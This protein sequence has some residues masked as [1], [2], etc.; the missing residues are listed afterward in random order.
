MGL[1]LVFAC[2]SNSGKD[3]MVTST[4]IW[5]GFTGTLYPWPFGAYQ[6]NDYIQHGDQLTH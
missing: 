2:D 3:S 4:A 6:P 1:G 5:K